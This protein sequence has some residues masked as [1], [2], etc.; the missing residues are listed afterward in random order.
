MSIK[1]AP[2][3]GSRLDASGIA[4]DLP[5]RGN[6]SRSGADVR[7]FRAAGKG[8]QHNDY[9]QSDARQSYGFRLVTDF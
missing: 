2:F 9:A 5:T 7:M 4:V 3:Q 6:L 1:N 8:G